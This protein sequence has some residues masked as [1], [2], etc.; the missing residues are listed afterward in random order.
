M[1][2]NTTVLFPFLFRIRLLFGSERHVPFSIAVGDGHIKEKMKAALLCFQEITGNSIISFLRVISFSPF[3]TAQPPSI[4]MEKNV[5]HM[6]IAVGHELNYWGVATLQINR[7]IP[8]S[9]PCCYHLANVLWAI[10]LFVSVRHRY[11][12]SSGW[13][14]PG[15]SGRRS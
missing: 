5:M 12:A 3:L 8:L 7:F 6:L 4:W 14:V 13:N 15:C 2:L 1:C 9:L 10:F 11:S